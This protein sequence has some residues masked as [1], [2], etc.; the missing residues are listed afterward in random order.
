[1]MKRN[2]YAEKRN[3]EKRTRWGAMKESRRR[4]EEMKARMLQ[5]FKCRWLDDFVH[6]TS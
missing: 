6:A 1:M 3:Q 4:R 2:E 5:I